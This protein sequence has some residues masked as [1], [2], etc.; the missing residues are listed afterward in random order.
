[1]KNLHEY[2]R[3]RANP[4]AQDDNSVK[5]S[6]C[7]QPAACQDLWDAQTITN[8]ETILSLNYNPGDG[9]VSIPIPA[10]DQVQVDD[11]TL[12]DVIAKA[13]KAYEYDTYVRAS[14]AAGD[15]TLKHVGEGTLVS[16]VTSG[17]VKTADSRT[18]TT[19][20]KCDHVADN[21]AGI[22]GPVTDGDGGSE[23]LANDPYAWTGTPATDDST[24][25]D[26]QTDLGTALT[27]LGITTDSITAVNNGV[28][29]Y[30]VTVRA[31]SPKTIILNGT[32]LRQTNCSQVFE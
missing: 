25:G 23:A 6:D 3:L 4:D 12:A 18:C 14:Y 15:L 16:F 8:T 7:D 20:Y 11:A 9:V 10:E 2:G 29:G 27:A 13:L 5:L 24:A 28:D 19:V 26:L 21:L 1:M 32:Q 22:L 17:G 31:N 30:L